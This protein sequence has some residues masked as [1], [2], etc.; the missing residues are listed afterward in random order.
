MLSV[1]IT[2]SIL[3][4]VSCLLAILSKRPIYSLLS[5]VV[6]FFSI[7]G[8]FLLLQ[9]QFLAVV[10]VIVYAGAIVV[11]FLFTIMLMNLNIPLFNKKSSIFILTSTV[12]CA[13]ILGLFI[14]FIH[15]SVFEPA[16][17]N[18]N[19]GDVK[20]LGKVLLN[21]YYFPFEFI[22]VLLLTAMIGAVLI[23]KKES[24]SN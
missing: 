9:S 15:E 10:Q 5:V 16:K 14:H 1:F 17:L 11:L 21:E 2:L 23:S 4:I 18:T 3:T 19:A 12:V 8:H 7:A 13:G 20:T 22:S 6:A 24:I